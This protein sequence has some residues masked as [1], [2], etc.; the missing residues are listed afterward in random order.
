MT[1]AKFKWNM[2]GFA[3]V[4]SGQAV[5]AQLASLAQRKAAQAGDGYEVR[6]PEVSRGRGRG[7][8]A[9]ITG[10]F[11]SRRAEATQHNLARG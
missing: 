4:R 3:E 5:T 9:V 8:A 7:R 10:D 11:R 6:G 1:V 2:A